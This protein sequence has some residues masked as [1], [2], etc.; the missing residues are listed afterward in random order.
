MN[1]AS[2][3]NLVGNFLGTKQEQKVN[4]QTGE[5]KSW[6]EIGVQVQVSDGFGGFAERTITVRIPHSKA[7]DGVSYYAQF[8]QKQVAVPVFMSP[9]SNG[10]G[11]TVFLA[12][13]PI[14]VLSAP[15]SK[16]A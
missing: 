9:W 3:Y 15:N 2:G 1:I 12:D 4:T 13:G 11:M 10:K 8:L 16:A 14:T 6:F 5:V 7:K